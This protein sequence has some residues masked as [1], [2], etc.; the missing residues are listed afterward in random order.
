MYSKTVWITLKSNKT[1]GT[2]KW[3]IPTPTESSSFCWSWYRQR[4]CRHCRCHASTRK[5]VINNITVERKQQQQKPRPFNIHSFIFNNVISVSVWNLCV[6]QSFTYITIEEKGAK[7][8]P[9]SRNEIWKKKKRIDRKWVKKASTRLAQ[10][11]RLE[12]NENKLNVCGFYLLLL[13]LLVLRAATKVGCS[14]ELIK[15]HFMNNQQRYVLYCNCLC[16][17]PFGTNSIK[18]QLLLSL[19]I[20]YIA[21]RSIDARHNE[22][23]SKM[24]VTIDVCTSLSIFYWQI[25]IKLFTLRWIQLHS[26]R[27]NA[28]I[29]QWK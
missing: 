3:I 28:H 21:P 8:S 16:L 27:H 22:I 9:Q 4:R 12:C 7:K 26:H 2:T 15:L 14:L 19:A 25:F 18:S 29:K 17:H 20:N 23:R 1:N 13:L 10:R 24:T 5:H 11:S 6:S